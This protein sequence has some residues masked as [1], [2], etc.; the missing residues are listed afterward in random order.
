MTK[1][2]KI[3]GIA[4]LV[5]ILALAAIGAVALAQDSG[6][7][8]DAP[9]NFAERLHQAIA[10]ALGISVETYDSAVDTAQKQVLGEAVSEGVLT[11][12]QADEIQERMDQGFGPGMHDGFFGLREG[13]FGRGFGPG[14]FPGDPEHSLMS[15]AA[16]KLGM[17][18]SDLATELQGGKSIADVAGEKGVNT[19][20]IASAY[21]TQLQDNLD[22]A[23]ADGRITQ[24]Q[25]DTMLQQAQERVPDMLSS[26]LEG[27]GHGGFRDGMRPGRFQG[28]PG[29]DDA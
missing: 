3:A 26:T 21:L 13:R 9:F 28:L 22:Q 23:V 12:D 10:D 16:E 6:N 18:A 29:Q 14:G 15:I 19:D 4:T 25:A 17:T 8:T 1:F 27:C 20:D 2:W 24:S 5:G 11:Q 7:G